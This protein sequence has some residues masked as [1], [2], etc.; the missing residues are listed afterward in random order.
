MLI[1]GIDFETTGLSA[2][3]DR[4]VEVGAVLMDWDTGLPVQILSKLIKPDRP[5]PPEITKINGIDDEMVDCY[6]ESEAKVFAELVSMVT[7]AD[8]AMAH[9]SV[10]DKGFYDAAVRRLEILDCGVLWLDTTVDIIWPSNITTRNLRHLAAEHNFLNPFAHRAVF[11]VM[12]MLRVAQNYSLDDIIARASEPT[13]YV[14]IFSDFNDKDK[15]KALGYRWFPSRK[16][17]WKS[18]KQSDYMA[19]R[20]TCGFRTELLEKAPE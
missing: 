20:D 9:N 1:L 16:M 2:T 19:E 5:I 13:L 14:Q 7:Q 17:W 11:D 12:T 4:I 6:G 8:Y 3:E 15:V 10:F 18:V